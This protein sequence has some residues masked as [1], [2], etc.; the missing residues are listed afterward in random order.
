MSPQQEVH[1][2]SDR[3]EC[4]TRDSQSQTWRLLTVNKPFG[5]WLRL[6]AMYPAQHGQPA[7]SAITLVGF[8]KSTKRWNIVSVD[9]DG[10]YYTRYSTSRDFNG[11]RWIDGDPADGGR[12][13]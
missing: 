3:F 5:A 7:G 2:L 8:D 9:G 13:I 10:T 4:I 6:D 11:S 12:A 1:S